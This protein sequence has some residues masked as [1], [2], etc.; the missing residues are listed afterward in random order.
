LK[1]DPRSAAALFAPRKLTQ[2]RQML[3][4]TRAE[5]ARRTEVSAASISQYESGAMRPRPATLAQLALVLNVPLEFLTDSRAATPLP[6]VDTSFFRSLRRTTQRDRERATAYAGLLA[7]LVAEI[8]RRVTL[9][10]FTP[11][12][13]LAL[14][15]DGEPEAA[16][17]AAVRIRSLWGLGAEPLAHAVRLMERHGVIVAQLPF[18]S[19]DVDAFS[20]ASG[21]RP[22]VLL[23][24][25]KGDFE[26]SR[27]DACHEL[28]H[29]LLHAADP[30]PAHPRME[31]Q[32]HRF[33]GALL[34]SAEALRDEWPRGRWDWNQMVR[35]KEHWGISIAAQLLRARDLGL[36]TADAY[37]SRVKYM[38]RMGWR[39]RE[40]GP[41]RPPE[42]PD[43]LNQAIGL[44]EQ[45]GTT[46]DMVA[47]EG[48]LLGRD[49]L[50][51]RLCLTPRSPLRVDP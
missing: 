28:A 11:T 18:S 36:L 39:R 40:P 9:P 5:L 35:I 43:L 34:I 49:V 3:A 8:E 4:I 44:L 15:P 26:R 14:D 48:N 1:L 16:E 51:E 37:V 46:L 20:W 38:S 42:K 19:N 30:E 50:L 13:D 23:G 21:P 17:A 25:D 10:E 6:T 7:Q 41:H 27:F 24:N 32:A 33:S 29:I 45:N 2:A 47:N 22:L 31:R 12:P